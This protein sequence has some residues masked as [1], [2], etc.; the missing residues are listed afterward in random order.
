MFSQLP[1][2]LSFGCCF[3]H[4][5]CF[6]KISSPVLPIAAAISSSLDWNLYADIGSLVNK[7]KCTPPDLVIQGSSGSPISSILSSRSF[8]SMG[9]SSTSIQPHL[10]VSS[11]VNGTTPIDRSP[12]KCFSQSSNVKGSSSVL[13]LPSFLTPFAVFFCPVISYIP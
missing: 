8:V 1:V 10:Q 9:Y 4:S 3:D 2:C 6:G 7:N 5:Y 12:F 13:P 11:S